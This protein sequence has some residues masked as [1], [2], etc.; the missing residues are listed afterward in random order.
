M[1]IGKRFEAFALY[2]FLGSRSAKDCRDTVRVR[3]AR[4]FR[5]LKQGFRCDLFDL[6]T[7]LSESPLLFCPVRGTQ[8]AA[9]SRLRSF[10]R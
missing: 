6:W 3:A 7:D 9:W 1:S 2:L 10:S 4:A 8:A 5:R